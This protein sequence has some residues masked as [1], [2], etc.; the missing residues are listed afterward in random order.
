MGEVEEKNGKEQ[1]KDWAWEERLGNQMAGTGL[2]KNKINAE[3]D[4]SYSNQAQ[5]K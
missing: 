1:R 3:M 5:V 2:N 4:V